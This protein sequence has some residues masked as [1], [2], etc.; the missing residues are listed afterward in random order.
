[1]VATVCATVATAEGTVPTT[2]EAG[3]ATTTTVAPAS[4]LAVPDEY[5]IPLPPYGDDTDVTEKIENDY[6]TDQLVT[7]LDVWSTGIA[8]T[9]SSLFYASWI[10]DNGNTIFDARS[11]EVLAFFSDC[12]PPTTTHTG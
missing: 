4:D 6:G 1:M 9:S 2:T 7:R 11:D 12:L 10:V 3:P 5:P 8:S